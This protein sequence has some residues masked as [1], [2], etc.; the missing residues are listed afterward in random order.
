MVATNTTIDRSGLK[1]DTNKVNAIGKG[2]LSGKPV[3]VRST[4]VIKYLADKSN[5]AFPI[6]GVGRNT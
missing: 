5:K 2:G 1:T 6:I 4:E 3:R